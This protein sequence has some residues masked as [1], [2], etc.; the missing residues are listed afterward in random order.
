L[1]RTD[2]LLRT[3]GIEFCRFVDDYYVFANTREEAHASLIHLS[4]V[5]LN[6]WPNFVSIKDALHVAI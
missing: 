4:D 3:E 2:R 5:L 6:N 1:N